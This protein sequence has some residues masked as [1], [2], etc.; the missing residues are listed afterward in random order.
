[1]AYAKALHAMGRGIVSAMRIV[2][3]GREDADFEVREIPRSDWKRLGQLFE[4][5]IPLSDAFRDAEREYKKSRRK[6][7]DVAA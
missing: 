2:R 4:A 7:A 6:A 1:V 3:I 5:C